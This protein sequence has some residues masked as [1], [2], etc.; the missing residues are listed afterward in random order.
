[1]FFYGGKEYWSFFFHSTL[2][3]TL[4][5]HPNGSYRYRYGYR[6]FLHYFYRVDD[7]FEEKRDGIQKNVVTLQGFSIYRKAFG[8]TAYYL[9]LIYIL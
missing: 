6:C 3:L 7:F 8:S 5:F 9:K 4:T 2:T 1:M